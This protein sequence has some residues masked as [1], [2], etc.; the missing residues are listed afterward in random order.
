MAVIRWLGTVAA[1]AQVS[2]GSIDSV[3]ATPANNTYTV[4]IG[5]VAIS[6]AGTVD[7]ATTATA[8]RAALNAS[9]HPYFSGITWS[10]SSGT[11]TGTSDNAGVPFLAALTETGAGTG[12]VTDFSTTTANAG[13]NVLAAANLSGGALP[14][15][16]DTLIFENSAIDVLWA[17]DAMTSTTTLTIVVYPTFTGKIGL[18]KRVF[19]ST[20]TASVTTAV[21]YR[22]DE[23]TIDGATLFH[24]PAHNGQTS[25][26]GS[27]RIVVNTKAS[28]AVF[29]IENTA[30]SATDSGLEPVRVR[31]TSIT[32]LTITGNSVVGICTQDFASDAATVTTLY[33]AGSA[34]VNAR[35]GTTLTTLNARDSA[36]V[37][38]ETAPTT[39]NAG[40]SSTSAV[41][42]TAAASGTV[43]TATIGPNVSLVHVGGACTI[44]T[45]NLAGKL[46]LTA[47]DGT[48]TLTTANVQSA[49]ARVID[50]ANKLATNTDFVFGANVSPGSVLGQLAGGRTLRKTA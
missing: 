47:A 27:G 28:A 20:A 46:D 25:P 6:Q 19:Q 10:G 11:I 7:V 12:A 13:P 38:I 30:T 31:G 22:E 23:L 43:T 17:L 45:L 21:E 50:P 32:S 44:T 37:R 34:K 4:T 42:T 39:I 41:V 15:N 16:G 24:M 2:T 5:G 18:N 1:V 9:T 8:L 36:N 26:S 49:S 40:D 29:R 14:S 35:L 48:M 3:D 33:A